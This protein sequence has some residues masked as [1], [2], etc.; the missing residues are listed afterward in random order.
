MTANEANNPKVF[1]DA[2]TYEIIGA[3]QKV[4][5]TLGPGFSEATYQ[6][7]ICKELM[8]RGVPFFS[9]KEYEVYYEGV[10]CGTYRPD[11]VVAEMVIVELKAVSEL[12]KEHRAQALS[13]LR[14]SNLPVALLLNFGSASLEVRRLKN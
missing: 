3:A 12:A 11:L 6:T 13:Y 8:I 1:P 2:L 7:A 14:A 4:H 5:R 9:Q 10:L